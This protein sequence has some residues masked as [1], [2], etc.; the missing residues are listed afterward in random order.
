MRRQGLKGLAPYLTAGDGGLETTLAVLRELDAAGVAAVELG[1]PFSDPIADGP[2]LQ[3]ASERALQAGTTLAGTLEMLREFRQGSR[4]AAGSDLPV[5]LM[6]YTN[7]LLR[8]GWWNTCQEVAQAGGDALIV[9]DLPVEESG[10]MREAALSAGLC[11][12]HFVAPT[13]SEE[14][15]R[16]AGAISCGFLYV[17]GRVGVTGARTQ[18]DASTQDFLAFVRQCTEAPLAVGFGVAAAKDV[19]E[20]TRHADLA[21]V[22]TALTA[23]MHKAA[24]ENQDFLS[25]SVHAAG[26]FVRDLLRGLA[27]AAVP[28]PDQN[29]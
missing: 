26:S 23:R 10:E 22:G 16:Q 8:R 15:I 20:A 14:R 1:I 29:S 21:I 12:V 6:S 13:T 18:F 28:E 25:A 11:P 17:V 24:S 19:S 5:A 3:A 9:A 27:V 4:G 7:P 2:V